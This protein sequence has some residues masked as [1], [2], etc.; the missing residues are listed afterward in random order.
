VIK[1]KVG[2]R[3]G[4]VDYEGWDTH[5]NQYARLAVGF[6]EFAA[7]LDA[8]SRDIGDMYED[9]VV[10]TMTEFGRTAR[11]N[12][13]RGTDHGHGSVM[14]VMGQNVRGGAVYGRW[15]GLSQDTLHETRD[16]A[17]TTDFR[18]VLAEIAGAGPGNRT[19]FPGHA[20]APDQVLHIMRS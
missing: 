15:P 5:I 1:L 2:L 13:A 4:F 14:L 16:L 7:A 17:V 19:L 11:L 3:V 6:K 8:F 10:F 12:G 20:I 18:D 9:I